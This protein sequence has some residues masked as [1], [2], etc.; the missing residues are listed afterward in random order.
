MEVIARDE[1]WEMS[2]V[3]EWVCMGDIFA[4]FTG[5][6]RPRSMRKSVGCDGSENATQGGDLHEYV[7]DKYEA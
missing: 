6:I 2:R 5:N 7:L 1:R 3:A 4:A